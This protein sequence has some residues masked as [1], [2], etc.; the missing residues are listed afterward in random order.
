MSRVTLPPKYTGDTVK[1]VFDFASLL[2]SGETISSAQTFCTVYSGVDANPQIVVSGAAAISGTQV[3]QALT[4]G[5]AGTC[6]WVRCEAVTSA[7]Q[8]L[9]LQGV[10]AVEGLGQL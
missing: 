7:S 8:T 5:V 1:Q 4:G 3:T 9:S 10:L 6:Y 2:A